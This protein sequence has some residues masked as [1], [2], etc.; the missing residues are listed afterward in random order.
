MSEP[1]KAEIERAL[2]P[3]RK[4]GTPE[5]NVQRAI[6]DLLT[7]KHIFAFRLNTAAVKV[8]GR[9]FRAHS[10]GK[11]AADILAFPRLELKVEYADGRTEA[12]IIVPLWIEVKAANGVQSPEQRSFALHVRTLGHDYLLAYSVEDVARWIE[13][14]R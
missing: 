10:L 7:A 4:K 12:M 9:F 5:G 14:H 13:E 2:F 3:K 1:T 8:E 11:G 6:L